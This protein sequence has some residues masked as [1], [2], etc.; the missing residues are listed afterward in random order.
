MAPVRERKSDQGVGGILAE[1][2]E[3][4]YGAWKIHSN[5]RAPRLQ[6]LVRE[7][8]IRKNP[9]SSVKDLK[10]IETVLHRGKILDRNRIDDLLQEAIQIVQKANQS[11]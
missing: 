7:A 2:E 9:L 1:H 11:K 8:G 10:T 4:V 3:L 6:L 5:P